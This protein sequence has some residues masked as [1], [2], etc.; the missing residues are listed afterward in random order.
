VVRLFYYLNPNTET[1]QKMDIT[2]VRYLNERN[3][4]CSKSLK[5]DI[6]KQ[7]CTVAI[8]GKMEVSR[9][10]KI[11]LRE[12]HSHGFTARAVTLPLL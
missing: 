10:P 11:P 3:R 6:K 5:F 9:P 2:L 12:V 8:N 4:A 1:E 7:K